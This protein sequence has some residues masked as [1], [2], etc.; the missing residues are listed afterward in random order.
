MKVATVLRSGGEFTPAHVLWLKRQVHEKFGFVC[1]SD[2][3]IEGVDVIPLEHDWPGWWAK[4]EIYNPVN[5]SEDLLY[6]DLDTVITGDISDMATETDFCILS[7]FYHPDKIQASV[8]FIPHREKARIW[9]AFITNPEEIMRRCVVPREN[10]GDQGFIGEMVSVPEI[11]QKKYP[12]Q[13]VGYKTDIASQNMPGWHSVRSRGDGTL[14]PDTR[15]VCF[16][17][18]PR[19]WDVSAD[20]IPPC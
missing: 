18:K 1:F 19:P 6:L 7:D 13:I 9:D 11:W 17:G 12:G 20:W 2:V 15:I 3:P 10:W 14:P 8:V 4:M 5:C 16:H